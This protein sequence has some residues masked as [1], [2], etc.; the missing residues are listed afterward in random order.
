[1][2]K[3]HGISIGELEKKSGV[4]RSII[5]YYVRLGLLHK[6]FKTGQTMAYYDQ[7]HL[8]KLETIQRIKIDFLKTSKT[9]RVPVDYI[10]HRLTDDYTFIK[11]KK[12]LKRSFQRAAR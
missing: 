7:S 9:S 5:H 12:E 6:P 11:G 2:T 4:G 8:R 1:M 10:M 3:R